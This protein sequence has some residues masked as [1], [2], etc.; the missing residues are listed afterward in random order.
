M[1]IESFHTG[2]LYYNSCDRYLNSFWPVC[3]TVPLLSP[4]LSCDL[5]I[6]SSMDKPSLLS[7][8]GSVLMST[9]KQAHLNMQQLQQRAAAIPPMV[10]HYSNPHF[11]MIRYAHSERQAH[12]GRQQGESM[13]YL[14]Q[15]PCQVS[16]SSP[17][18]F[19]PT[20]QSINLLPIIN[21]LS[22][23][24]LSNVSAWI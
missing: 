24:Q 4:P 11:S 17:A 20:C 13:S 8:P 22:F 9:A 18:F 7:P 3:L 23:N 6:F 12:G 5:R 21:L 15:P 16:P 2:L 14:D 10:S 1:V 19:Q